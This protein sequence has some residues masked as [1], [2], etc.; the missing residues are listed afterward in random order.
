[1]R[2]DAP[3]C[4]RLRRSLLDRGQVLATL[5]AELL[6]GKDKTRSIDALGLNAR[7]G[8]RPEEILRAAL[9][10][11]EALR[12][13]IEAGDDRYGRCHVC[14]DDLGLAALTEVPWSDA[15]HAHAG[16]AR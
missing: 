3:T 16:L 9:D 15:C 11:V 1:M 8:M 7:P 2:F 14:G 12:K 6:A 13:Q 4:A 10:H 5:L